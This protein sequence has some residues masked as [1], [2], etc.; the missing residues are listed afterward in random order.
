M[1]LCFFKRSTKQ[2]NHDCQECLRRLI[3]GGVT[4]EIVFLIDLTLI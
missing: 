2:L 4:Q 1:D 3:L